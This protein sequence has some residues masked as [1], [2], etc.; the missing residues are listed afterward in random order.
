[1]LKYKSTV[2]LL[3]LGAFVLTACPKNEDP[4]ADDDVDTS[5]NGHIDTGELD[6]TQAMD[7]VDAPELPVSRQPGD[8][9][10]SSN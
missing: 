3:A 2:T 4:P 8:E 1:M 5:S 10:P 6:L 7:R 9:T